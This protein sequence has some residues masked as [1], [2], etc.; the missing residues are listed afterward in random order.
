MLL[1]VF[2]LC[3]EMDMVSEKALGGPCLKLGH[4]SPSLSPQAPLSS[5][6]ATS[7][8]TGEKPRRTKPEKTVTYPR[9][10]DGFTT[11]LDQTQVS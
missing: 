9:A 4:I 11:E 1:L 7:V 2:V 3:A 10:H 6:E 8:G 5:K